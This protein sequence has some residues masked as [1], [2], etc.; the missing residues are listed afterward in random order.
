[1]TLSP[2]M[3]GLVQ[4][5]RYSIANALELV[6]HA[7]THCSDCE[8]VVT[9][10]ILFKMACVISLQHVLNIKCAIVA[11]S[12]TNH[13]KKSFHI[14]FPCASQYLISQD[15]FTN[16]CWIV[17]HRPFGFRGNKL[18]KIVKKYLLL[19]SS[20]NQLGI[21]NMPAYL[22]LLKKRFGVYLRMIWT[23]FMTFASMFPCSESFCHLSHWK[24]QM[25]IKSGV[26][27]FLVSLLLQNHSMT[28]KL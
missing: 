26:K 9:D 3:D 17:L 1:M 7:L 4:E 6:F 8:H 12:L 16:I 22:E 23:Y 27:W 18:A 20:N 28:R 15:G 2:W 14:A 24:L 19:E 21:K 10:E 13:F 25:S 11:S 5:R